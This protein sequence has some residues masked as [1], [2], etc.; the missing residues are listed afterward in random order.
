MS[1]SLPS[2]ESFYKV[3]VSA[4]HK[5]CKHC[6]TGEYWTIVYHDGREEIEI[7]SS[8]QDKET[9]EDIC[10]LMNMA[11]HFGQESRA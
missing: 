10:D 7:G 1:N 5:G 6:G 2:E 4:N 9:A 8:W 11:Y 3:E